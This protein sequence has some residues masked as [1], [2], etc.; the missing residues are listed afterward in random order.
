ME[1]AYTY[2]VM[3]LGVPEDVFW[4]CDVAFVLG[5]VQ[6]KASYDK[7]LGRMEERERKKHENKAKRR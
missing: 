1:D 3:L 2:Y 5:I 7:W 4:H 6:N